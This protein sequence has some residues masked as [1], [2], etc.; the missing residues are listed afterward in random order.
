MGMCCGQMIVSFRPQVVFSIVLPPWFRQ[1]PAG[2]FMLGCADLF[3]QFV[4]SLGREFLSGAERTEDIH[5]QR[6]QPRKAQASPH[7]ASG[8]ER[9]PSKGR[10][11][12]RRSYS[13]RLAPRFRLH[14]VRT[15]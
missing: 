10:A 14:V 6:L 13:Y 15:P 7:Q 5:P 1:Q 9:V 8:L 2:E 4:E 3:E 12:I 11:A